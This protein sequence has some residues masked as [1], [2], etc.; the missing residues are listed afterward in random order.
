MHGRPFLQRSETTAVNLQIVALP[1][2]A[3]RKERLMRDA[4]IAD[5]HHAEARPCCR[6]SR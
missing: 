4:L 3:T 2:W 1:T 6:I 5:T